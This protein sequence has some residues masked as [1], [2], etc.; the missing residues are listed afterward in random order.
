MLTA[1]HL[2]VRYG[3]GALGIEDVS[4]KVDPG[5]MVS[6]T[7]A[8]GAGKSTTVRALS[9]FM[10]SENARVVTGTVQLF[11]RDVTNAQPSYM[12]SLG[13]TVVPE[14]SKVFPN[15]TV[16]EN[17]ISQG[18]LPPKR[19]RPERLEALLELFP[20]L[21]PRMRTPAGL[22]S[23][24]QQQMLAIGRMMM[25]NSS[26]IIVD[27]VTLGL[28]VSLHG[29]LYEAIR[30]LAHGDR[31]ALVV[32]EELTPIAESLVDRHYAIDSGRVREA[33]TLGSGVE[34]GTK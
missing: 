14:R 11:D 15:L 12:H 5:E 31:A 1:N 27:E 25:T 13:V 26:L 6:L 22:L 23:G 32:D 24:G 30:Y 21:R 18:Q 33:T 7:G 34:A 8:C 2:A 4:L 10:K 28:H 16:R 17:L 29:P 9:G 19:E 3:N 20:V